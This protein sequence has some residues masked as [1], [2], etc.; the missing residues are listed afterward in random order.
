MRLS[1]LIPF[2]AAALALSACG[3][4]PTPK[5]PLPTNAVTTPIAPP[6]AP[7]T[8]APAPAV[9]ACP[10]APQPVCPPAATVQKAKASA[11]P[12]RRHKAKPQ[13][14]ARR[15]GGSHHY[16]RYRDEHHRRDYA[17]GHERREHHDRWRGGGREHRYVEPA[18]ADDRYAY[19]DAHIHAW[20]QD[21]AVARYAAPPYG[22]ARRYEDRYSGGSH[23]S[24]GYESYE[25]SESYAYG[26]ADG[27][28]YYERRE[29]QD[30]RRHGGSTYRGES[31]HAY[32]EHAGRDHYGSSRYSERYS[33][34]SYDSGWRTEAVSSHPGC[35]ASRQEAAG[36]DHQGY[37]TWPGKTPA[38]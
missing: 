37:L 18:P 11:Q 32:S 6:P 17:R 14:H 13:Q 21:G 2:A 10:P 19:G 16:E 8:A 24:S 38:Y 15:S 7:A 22:E 36:R 35:C 5:P 31:P 34:R 27:H 1:A 28:R 3:E 4:Q 29:P 23:R 30:D 12:A 26:D 9:A 20:G 33:E 25:R